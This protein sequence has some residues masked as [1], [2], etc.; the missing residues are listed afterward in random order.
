VI[1]ATWEAE[2]GESR[3]KAILG[4]VSMRPYLKNKLNTKALGGVAQVED[5]LLTKHKVLNL[6]PSKEKI[7]V[8][9]I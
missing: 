8:L 2:E 4:K 9:A 1:P 7:S 6:I 3:F 5:C